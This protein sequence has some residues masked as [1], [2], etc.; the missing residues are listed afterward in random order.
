LDPYYVKPK[1]DDF[2]E[3]VKKI[4]LFFPGPPQTRY[5]LS[6]FYISKKALKN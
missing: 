3:F 4:F 1:L 2:G 5:T 6:F